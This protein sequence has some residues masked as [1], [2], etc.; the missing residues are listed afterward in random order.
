MSANWHLG[1]V[2]DGYFWK[3]LILSPEVFIFLSF[4]ITDP[5]TVPTGRMARRIYAVS[6]GL[7]SALL[8]APQTTEFGAKV[9]LLGSLTL[10]CAARPI[11]ILLGEATAAQR[12]WLGARLA[13]VFA[14]LRAARRGAI[15]AGALGAAGLF[16]IALVLAGIPARSSAEAGGSAAAGAAVA[17]VTIS[18]KPGVSPIDMATGR[19][20]ARDDRR[21]PRRRGGGAPQPGRPSCGRGREWRMA[22]AAADADPRRGRRLGRRSGL[23]HRPRPHLARAWRRTGAAA[24]RHDARG[25]GRALDLLTRLAG[26]PGGRHAVQAVVRARAPGRQVRDRGRPQRGGHDALQ[27]EGRDLSS[28]RG[29]EGH[30]RLRGRAAHRRRR[31]GGDPLPPGR[32]PLRDVRG[33]AG[34]DGRRR[35]LA[36]LQQRRLDGPVRRQLLRRRERV[37][38]AEARWLPA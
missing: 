26:E 3:V 4:M 12:G 6:I 30:R 35:L 11:L 8:I 7:L 18:A 22:R 33:C 38:M 9:A 10:V 19:R 31:E 36:R 14:R 16:A 27:G 1:P 37:G 34:H 21:R 13:L 29:L 15:G 25:N 2:S 5:K 28:G 23:S 32:V 20:I 17:N 24:G